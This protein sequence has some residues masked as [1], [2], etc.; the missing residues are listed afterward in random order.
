MSSSVH[1]VVMDDEPEFADFVRYVAEEQG[2]R[3]V[4]PASAAEFKRQVAQLSP[5]LIVLDLHMPEA[6]GIELLRHM[7]QTGAAARVMLISGTD[8]KL[9]ETARRLGERQGLDIVAVLQKPVMLDDLNQALGELRERRTGFSA[10]D[11]TVALETRQIE[12][13]YQP[14]IDLAAA[15]RMFGVEALA[16]WEHPRHGLLLP[17]SFLPLAEASDLMP[18]FTDYVFDAALRRLKLWR[19]AGFDIPMSVNLPAHFFNDLDLPDRL[20]ALARTHMVAPRKLTLEVKESSAM[21]DVERATEALTRFRH[22]G[23]ALALDD[24]GTGSASLSHLRRMSFTE[25]KIDGQIVRDLA[26]S[27]HSQSIVKALVALGK[28]LGLKVCAEG[29]EDAR[30]LQLL[31]QLDCDF[32]QGFLFSAA[33]PNR[34]LLARIRAEVGDASPTEEAR[35]PL[36]TPDLAIPGRHWALVGGHA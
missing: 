5:A 28:G 3:V 19:L 34:E 20:A 24:F 31:R 36:R 8:R 10:R 1:L 16:R 11:L 17:Q 14:R 30:A 29:I 12:L 7:A 18:T 4:A 2:F 22:E 32:A 26:R 27:R 33:L 15:G 13:Y 21:M 6:D 35:A 9:L 23:F 25:L